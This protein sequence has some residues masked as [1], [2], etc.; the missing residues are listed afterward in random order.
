MAPTLSEFAPRYLLEDCGHLAASTR[1]DRAVYLKAGAP[2]LHG[3]G[4][5]QLDDIDVPALRAWWGRYVDGRRSVATGRAYLNVLA[6]VLHYAGDVGELSEGAAVVSRFRV[7]LRRRL[8]TKGERASAEATVAPLTH[9]ETH[10]LISTARAH[11]SVAYLHVLLCLDAG[12]RPGE[13]M[14]LEWGDIEDTALVIR[15]NRPRGGDRDTTKS[16][17]SRRVYLSKRL[18]GA[19]RAWRTIVRWNDPR[20]LGKLH[21]SNFNRRVMRE[22]WEQAG[23]ADHRLKD[24]RDTFASLL[25]TWGVSPAYISKQ[26]G[27]AD[28]AVTAKH[29]AVYVSDEFCQPIPLQKGEGP[30]D[31]LGK[32]ALAQAA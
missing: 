25:L 14:G 2:L 19:L 8:R 5:L 4:H 6:C 15:H 30:A 7:V 29:Y 16:G 27:H 13:A 11:S 12:L 28:W 26:L 3:I 17:R 20:V 24:L 9:G 18:A 10:R 23:L 22:V 32:P 1:A 21:P 31:L